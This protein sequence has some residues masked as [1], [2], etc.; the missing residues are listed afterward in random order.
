ME[1]ERCLSL[2]A[3]IFSTYFF[4]D[5]HLTSIVIIEQTGVLNYSAIDT[6]Y[7]HLYAFI[8]P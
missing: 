2:Y 8:F 5:L 1:K 7:C 3:S 6:G 4:I